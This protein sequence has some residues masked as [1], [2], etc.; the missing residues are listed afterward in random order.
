MPQKRRYQMTLRDKPT[1][2]NLGWRLSSVRTTPYGLTRS[3][4]NLK[5]PFH[6]LK[7]HVI[8]LNAPLPL[9]FQP[10]KR[11]TPFKPPPPSSTSSRS[12]PRSQSKTPRSRPKLNSPNFTRCASSR[13]FATARTPIPRTRRRSLCLNLGMGRL[14]LSL[15]KSS[16]IRM[17][18]RCA[19]SMVPWI[20][21]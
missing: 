19:G 16:L 7:S 21:I 3:Q 2:S 1:S 17:T 8:H 5:L 11:Q 10:G 14:A 18:R 12:G 9:I 13:P 20:E 6:P 15:G 4:S